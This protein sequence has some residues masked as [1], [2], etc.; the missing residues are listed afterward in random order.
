M[1]RHTRWIGW[2]TLAV[3]FAVAALA[4]SNI[5]AE[6]SIA[7][8]ALV[9]DAWLNVKPDGVPKVANFKGRVT[10]LHFWT[11]DCINCRR[12][13]PYI[14]KWAARYKASDVQVIGIHTPELPEERDP[15]NVRAAVKALGIT[16]PVLIDGQNKNWNDYRQQ[17]WPTVYVID[18]QG[19]VRY[20]WSGELQW[21]GEDGFGQLTAAI[22]K[23]RKE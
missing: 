5:A 13:L 7:A 15:A 18:K 16:Y 1:R 10:I 11:F 20:Q 2:L 8:P 19:N 12:N 22:E 4:A 23:L 14:A 9:G 3:V 6:P 17:V 21:N